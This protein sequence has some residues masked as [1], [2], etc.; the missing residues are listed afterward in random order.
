MPLYIADYLADTAHLGCAESGAYLHLIMSYWQRGGLPNDDNKLASIAR[1]TP[2]QW[3]C[4]KDTIAEFFSDGWVHRRVDLEL[5]KSQQAYEKRAFAGK[6]GG[7]S[8]ASNARAMLQQKAS[9]AL[10]TTTTYKKEK[11]TK[12]E[13]S[14]DEFQKW[15]QQFWDR[16][17]HKVARGRAETALVKALKKATIE[18][19]LEGVDKYRNSLNDLKYIK[20]PAGWLHDERWLDQPASAAK[21]AAA[22]NGED[23][24]VDVRRVPLPN[25]KQQFYIKADTPQW[26]AWRNFKIKTTGIAPSRDIDGGWYFPSE[27]PP[28]ER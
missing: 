10:P 7:L 14:A 11:N 21:P 28:E 25:G 17:G 22:T 8:K 5:A 18:R 19:I 16:Y 15:F 1:A 26:E 27:Y 12:K 4:M 3:C 2:E 23:K 9:N 13:K 6:S 20:D 24:T